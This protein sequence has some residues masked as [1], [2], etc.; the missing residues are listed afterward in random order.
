MNKKT[1]CLV[2]SSCYG[3]HIPDV[4]STKN[5]SIHCKILKG[6]KNQFDLHKHLYLAVSISTD[7]FC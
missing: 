2:S 1:L 6:L 4:F 5:L 3:Q 7:V